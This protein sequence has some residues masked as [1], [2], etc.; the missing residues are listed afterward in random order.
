MIYDSQGLG[1]SSPQFN[2]G[3]RSAKVK[4][5]YHSYVEQ[6]LIIHK[7]VMPGFGDLQAGTVMAKYGDQ[8]VPYVPAAI[9]TTD[10][11][12]VFL[13]QDA[14]S[15]T[16][17]YILNKYSSRFAVGQTL[18]AQDTAST[19]LGAITAIDIDDLPGLTKITV[20]NA[21]PASGTVANSVNIFHKTKTSSPYSAAAYIMDQAVSTGEYVEGGPD[22]VGAETS[23]VVSNA[24]LYASALVGLDSAAATSVGATT[25]TP[26]VIIK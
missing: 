23:V 15:G 3:G 24:V 26:Y 25:D 5:I 19:D 4:P 20:T 11:G 7:H 10:V 9:A 14:A 6:A 2:V 8:L 22:A 12:R 21:F 13:V 18:A 17:A 1:G 16:T